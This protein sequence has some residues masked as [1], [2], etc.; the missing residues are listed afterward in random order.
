MRRLFTGAAQLTEAPPFPGLRSWGIVEQDQL[1]AR[2]ARG[3]AGCGRQR[4]WRY[5]E[6][7]TFLGC[8]VRGSQAPCS[9]EIPTLGVGKAA[10]EQHRAPSPACAF[11]LGW[12]S[13]ELCHPICTRCLISLAIPISSCL[14]AD[15]D[16]RCQTRCRVLFLPQREQLLAADDLFGLCNHRN[17]LQLCKVLVG[18]VLCSSK[19][20]L[21]WALVLLETALNSHAYH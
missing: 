17:R 8:S 12:G 18:K 6:W 9:P 4:C 10:G 7:V 5:W 16:V 14:K 3:R 11:P 21:P 20:H 1:L 13:S 15:C 2:R 19:S